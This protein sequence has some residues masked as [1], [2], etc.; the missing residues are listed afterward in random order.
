MSEQ[1][2]EQGVPSLPP[3]FQQ[4]ADDLIAWTKLKV[5]RAMTQPR[6]ADVLERDLATIHQKWRATNP[7]SAKRAAAKLSRLAT[8]YAR[9]PR[10]ARFAGVNM[11]AP[12]SLDAVDFV[13]RNLTAA[14]VGPLITRI[15]GG[16]LVI[17]PPI[18]PEA[19]NKIPRLHT[20]YLKCL[21]ETD[22][23][24]SSD[25]IVWSVTWVTPTGDTGYRWWRRVDFD[26]G[27]TKSIDWTGSF[28]VPQKWPNKFS[29]VFSMLEEDQTNAAQV[30]EQTWLKLKD[31]VHEYIEK[32]GQWI[33]GLIGFSEIGS[34]ISAILKW[35]V[36]SIIGWLISIFAPDPMGTFTYTVTLNGGMNWT[37]TGNTILPVTITHTGSGGKYHAGLEFILA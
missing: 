27:E 34:I 21:D 20:K 17:A 36:D 1:I 10:F 13:P 7:D 28:N 19:T 37:A 25:E 18:A 23:W 5:A 33:A 24:S 30:V 9:D 32:F 31:K 3:Q 8:K 4:F 14:E 15:G 12:G 11:A 29:F 16:P 2:L 6:S 26:K 35:I 22:E